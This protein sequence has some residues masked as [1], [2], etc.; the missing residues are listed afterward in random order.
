[1]NITNLQVTSQP[2]YENRLLGMIQGHLMGD[3]LGAPHEFR[4]NRSYIFS[5]KLEHKSRRT[6]RFQG[7]K[8]AVVGQFT[9]D[10]EMTLTLL[11]SLAK[12]RGSY[13]RDQTILMYMEWAS[14][15]P[16]GMGI[17]TRKLLSGIKTL[18]GYQNRWNK[19]YGQGIIRNQEPESN[20]SLMR[21]SPLAVIYDNNPVI[22]DCNIT[23]PTPHNQDA[24][25]V[26][27]TAVRLALQGTPKEIIIQTVKT[28]AQ[29][30]KVKSA[31]AHALHKDGY[32]PKY[33]PREGDLIQPYQVAGDAKGKMK[34]WVL[35]AL[36]VSFRIF[37]ST[38]D[39]QQ[40]VETAIKWGGDTDTNAAIVG[41]L[42]GAF[43][44]SSQMM[45]NTT[46]STNWRI[47]IEA[48]PNL[49]DYPRP[50]QYRPNDIE[51]LISNIAVQY[52][53]PSWKSED[54]NET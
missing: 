39:Y 46:T 48:N 12:S 3:A 8:E 41:A 30:K 16:M 34:G 54:N 32:D 36:Y 26:Y 9:D 47:L 49:G 33:P 19:Y 21:A 43:Y 42:C 18:K 13:N 44:G 28:V 45:L 11:R 1:M 38:T 37:N 52:P 14:S 6:S 25:L 40:A 4:Y 23:N 15:K 7:T 29:T 50:S 22:Q 51:S 17:N 31:L 24:N 27:V 53:L 35:I 5:G 20:G 2:N 10:G